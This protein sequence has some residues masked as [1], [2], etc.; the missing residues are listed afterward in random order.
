MGLLFACLL[1]GLPALGALIDVMMTPR[2]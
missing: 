2:V 1:I